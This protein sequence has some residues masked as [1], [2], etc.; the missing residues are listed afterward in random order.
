VLE[1]APAREERVD[2]LERSPERGRSRPSGTRGARAG[3]R[4]AGLRACARAAR[5][6]RR[7]PSC[8][9]G[10]RRCC[11]R[12]SGVRRGG[13]PGRDSCR[14]RRCMRARRAQTARILQRLRAR[15][16]FRR[17]PQP[18]SQCSLRRTR[19]PSTIVITRRA[20]WRPP[21]RLLAGSGAERNP[22][23]DPRL[24]RVDIAVQL[25]VL[26]CLVIGL[27]VALI[28]VRRPTCACRRS[29]IARLLRGVPSA[30]QRRAGRTLPVILWGT[31]FPLISEAVTGEVR[32]RWAAVVQPATT[33]LALCSYNW[34]GLGCGGLEE[35]HA[36]VVRACHP[37]A[38]SRHAIALVAL[39]AFTDAKS[40]PSLMMFSPSWPR[41]S[42][43]ARRA[44]RVIAGES[45]PWALARRTGSGSAIAM[46]GAQVAAWPSPEAR[47]GRSRSLYAPGRGTSCRR[48]G[49]GRRFA[50]VGVSTEPS[51]RIPDRPRRTPPH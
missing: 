47:L 5:T 1:V 21:T 7:R 6:P 36:P 16:P 24:R 39:L 49:A 15:R 30:E 23:L 8:R 46:L 11:P 42:G 32:E 44:R 10:C 41:S 20:P 45:W 12:W 19:A 22:R 27:S 28:L 17:T 18:I 48:R 33:P 37:G 43:A 51:P 38:R 13:P 25:L 50:A 31:F 14:Q 4:A 34:R 3:A 29:S 35:G 40:V 9:R 2:S 26:I